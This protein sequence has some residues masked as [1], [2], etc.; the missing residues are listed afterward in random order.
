MKPLSSTKHHEEVSSNRSEEDKQGES[1][2][3]INIHKRPISC[4]PTLNGRKIKYLEKTLSASQRDQ[5]LIREANEDSDLTEAIQQSTEA[6]S[7]SIKD[8]SKAITEL[9]AGISNSI[10]MLA[11]VL[12]QP[13]MSPVNQNLFYQSSYRNPQ[14]TSSSGY[15]E[16][17][18]QRSQDYY[19][20]GW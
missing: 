12:Q 13:S 18:N 19:E 2:C 8:V 7:Q 16:A 17:I 9:G 1:I 11:Q 14:N 4:I 3:E 20:T 10:Q 6:F 15:S 5:L